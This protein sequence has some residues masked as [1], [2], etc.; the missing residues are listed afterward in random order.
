MT[1][2]TP[3]PVDELLDRLALF[4][5]TEFPV[6]SLYL[7]TR[8]S[9]VARPLFEPF[10]RKELKGR[11]ESYPLR[12]PERESLEADAERI[13]TFLRDEL[14]KRAQSVAI[15][16]CSAADLFDTM[17]LEA[18]LV[19]RAEP[20]NVLHVGRQP[21][22][23]PLA[24]LADRYRRYAALLTDTHQARIFVFG[25]GTELDQST[26]ENPKTRRTTVGGWSQM[27]YQRHIDQQH[28]KHAKEVA[29][30]LERIVQDEGIQH[31]VI[32]GDE[33]ILPL[34]REELSKELLEKVIDTLSL[35]VDTP[36]HE[37]LSAT[38]ESFRRHDSATDV[39]VVTRLIDEYRGDGLAVVGLH[40]TLAGLETGQIDEL[41]LVAAPIGLDRNAE[42]RPDPSTPTP[43]MA[44]EEVARREALA[45]DLVARARRTGASVRFIE[46]V[47]LLWD[48]GGVGAFLRYRLTPDGPAVPPVDVEEPE[49]MQ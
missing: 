49:A 10:V 12:S 47:N 45:G 27:R 36:E 23:Y 30:A 32:A 28:L 8:R 16:A 37:V 20:E 19:E 7:D 5:P 44:P 33:V 25:L 6:L 24:R 1:T 2:K 48:Q 9:D 40:D 46:D 21:H 4:E 11:I 3:T 14:D 13:Q 43:D 35:N 41:V 17:T 39:D 15:F 34:V 26:V 29:T 31:V 22:L 38:L 18:P 42:P